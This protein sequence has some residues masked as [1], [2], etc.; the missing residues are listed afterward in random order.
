VHVTASWGE[1]VV[2]ALA[3]DGGGSL[4]GDRL[5]AGIGRAGER[6]EGGHDGDDEGG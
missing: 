4:G 6:D 5:A 2:Q 1:V 3:F